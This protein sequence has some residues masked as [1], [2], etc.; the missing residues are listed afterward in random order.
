M[1]TCTEYRGDRDEWGTV[2]NG[3]GGG[4]RMRRCTE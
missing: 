3:G 4:Y 2:K 1:R